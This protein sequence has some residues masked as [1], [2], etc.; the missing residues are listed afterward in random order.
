MHKG[1]QTSS[2]ALL[3]IQTDPVQ[4]IT[5]PDRIQCKRNARSIGLELF[6]PALAASSA[7]EAGNNKHPYY[8][9]T[10]PMSFKH[11]TLHKI[12]RHVNSIL[13]V[14]LCNVRACIALPLN[15][16]K[17]DLSVLRW[18]RQQAPSLGRLTWGRGHLRRTE[19][20]TGLEGYGRVP[21]K[22]GRG[23]CWLAGVVAYCCKRPLQTPLKSS[24]N[25]R[26]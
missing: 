4:W 20:Q 7:S 23:D 15:N 13:R 3:D 19:W 11:T 18:D 24:A 22:K 14:K 25:A 26:Y 17:L 12:S 16:V 2:Y 6:W 9:I 8:S 10:R 21:C 5:R 1:E